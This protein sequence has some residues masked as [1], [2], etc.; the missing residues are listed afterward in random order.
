MNSNFK[1]FNIIWVNRSLTWKSRQ[2]NG[3]ETGV[4]KRQESWRCRLK[5]MLL[6]KQCVKTT[7]LRKSEAGWRGRAETKV[8][9]HTKEESAH[10]VVWNDLAISRVFN[11]TVG[12]CRNICIQLTAMSPAM[13]TLAVVSITLVCLL[14]SRVSVEQDI[15]SIGFKLDP[16]LLHVSYK[17]KL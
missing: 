16:M 7:A 4:G 2:L 8:A 10:C 15:N 1:L 5:R 12:K 11:W 17:R 3:V 13:N 14:H 9:L 6:L